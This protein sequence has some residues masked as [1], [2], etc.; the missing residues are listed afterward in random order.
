[1]ESGWAGAHALTI[2]QRAGVSRGALHHHFPD[3]RYGLAA[4]LVE[5]LL[6][7]QLAGMPQCDSPLATMK[8][9][10]RQLAEHPDDPAQLILMELWMA[11]R[12]DTR[13]QETVLPVI[14]A[15]SQ[16]MMASV[17]EHPAPDSQSG[18]DTLLS[19]L[20]LQGASMQLFSR[21]YDRRLLQ[22]ALYRF[23]ELLD[24][25]PGPH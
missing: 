12:S 8:A 17:T 1:M 18:L 2:C 25:D 24:A 20:V 15:G 3:G 14:H 16:R 21:S 9:T 4:L 23:L 6:E 19:R 11:S 5:Q 10:L 7:Q 22:Q 13:L